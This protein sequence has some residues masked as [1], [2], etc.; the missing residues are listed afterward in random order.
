MTGFNPCALVPSRNHH[1]AL[2]QVV[3]GLR[4]L[5]LPVLIVDDGS[6]E[7]AAAAIAALHDPDGGVIVHRRPFNGGKGA[8]VSDGFR[9]LHAQGFSHA[10]QVDADGQ[11]DLAAL[12]ALLE[13][14]R[15]HPTALVSGAPIYDDS[16]P[17]ARRIGRW[18][19][20]VWV[21]VETLSLRITDSMCGFRVYP[22]A[23]C[24]DLLAREKVGARM[25]FDTD[26]MVRLF[27]RGI[28]PIM[29]PVRVTYP[30]GNTSNFD[31]W[32][33]NLRISWMHT[34][35]VLTMLARLPS[36]LRHRPPAIG[37]A[38]SHWAGL[39]E[40][41][42][43]WGLW[44]TAWVYAHLGRGAC[45][46]LL[47]PVVGYFHLTGAEQR[48]AS[49][50]FLGRVLKRQPRAWDCYRHALDFAIRAVDTI[51]AWSGRLPAEALRVE[52]PDTLAAAAA[53]PKGAVLVVCHH[54]NAEL[55][56]A[57]MDPALRGRLTVLVH[58]RHAENF[59]AV[60][61][62]FNPEAALRLIQ[63]TDLGPDTAIA[64][65]ERV[66]RGEWIA[67]AGDRVP[68]LSQGRVVEAAFLGETAEFSVGPWVLA[69][70]LECPVHL[71]FCRRTGAGEWSMVLERFADRVEL[72]RGRRAEAL[73]QLVQA[74]A[75]RLESQCRR[76]PYQWY[77]FFDF[78]A[79]GA[80]RG[81]LG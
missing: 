47:A 55:A 71:L 10:V 9:L 68:V 70:L 2:P 30:P 65:Q 26:I 58:T 17:R 13:Q 24:L 18:F 36:I 40:R 4:A 34:R 35:L 20:H 22:L 15:A 52:N 42:A 14:A 6:D 73:R 27:W 53:E 16:M 12:P 63:V 48:L 77:N 50:Q 81:D 78:W 72:P 54:G 56:R 39:A 66:E 44:L 3:A 49:R 61:R 41:G 79:Q 51:A 75:A 29:V 74:Y 57:L 8:A 45:L 76:D 28:A 60:L 64:L 1:L 37:T 19:T 38:P 7:T 46:A 32:R 11:H 80:R 5:G 62:R 21:F 67:I 33:D 59:N 43:A 25:D 23:P 69:A 31:I